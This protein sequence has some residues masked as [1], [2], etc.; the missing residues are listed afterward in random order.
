MLSESYLKNPRMSQS[1]LKKILDGVEEFKWHLDNL[2]EETDAMKLGSAVH[3]LLLQPDKC[4]DMV[5]TPKFDGRTK[6]GKISRQKFEEQ[7]PPRKYFLISEDL[8]KK[9]HAMVEAIRQN[10][11][12]LQIVNSCEEF[13]KEYYFDYKKIPFK[14][15]VDG[16]GQKFVL[17]VKTTRCENKEWQIKNEILNRGYHFQ[18]AA[19]LEA[20][21]K[22]NFYIIFVRNEPP[23]AVFPVKLSQETIDNGRFLLDAACETY[24]ECLRTNPEFKPNNRLKII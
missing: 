11:D 22:D 18:A 23:Y 4:E 24:K 8:Y 19:Y 6:E 15:Q 1:K 9:A 17:D 14:A 12:A 20:T 2:P 16:V 7:Y 5:I 3:L 13:E 21:G 10:S